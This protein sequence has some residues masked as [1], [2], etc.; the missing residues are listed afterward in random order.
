MSSSSSHIDKPSEWEKMVQIATD[1]HS[2][3]DANVPLEL[4]DEGLSP[5]RCILLEMARDKLLVYK[6]E[7]T[8]R[9]ALKDA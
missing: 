5:A 6:Y 3:K 8:H 4:T 2:N 7:N 1:L 9:I